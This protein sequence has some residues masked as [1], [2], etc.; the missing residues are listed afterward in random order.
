MA[1]LDATLDILGAV[2]L[3]SGLTDEELEALGQTRVVPE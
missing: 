3:F 1:K 2:P